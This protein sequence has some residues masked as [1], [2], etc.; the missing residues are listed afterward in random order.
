MQTDQIRIQEVEP[1]VITVCEKNQALPE[2]FRNSK[3]KIV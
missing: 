2:D 3:M 1:P